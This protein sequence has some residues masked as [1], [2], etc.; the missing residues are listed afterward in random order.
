MVKNPP[1]NAWGIGPCHPLVQEDPACL[2]ATKPTPQILKATPWSPWSATG[3]ATAVRSLCTTASWQPRLAAT[4]ESPCAATKTQC[5]QKKKK[6]KIVI[7]DIIEAA[8]IRDDNFESSVFDISVLPKVYVKQHYWVNCTIH[9][10]VVNQASFSE[11]A[12]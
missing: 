10:K 2:G 12:P 4:R 11:S 7:R 9:S 6:K 8:A 1:P 5:G 3:E